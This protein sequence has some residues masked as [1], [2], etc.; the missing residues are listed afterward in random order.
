MLRPTLSTPRL[1]L[2]PFTLDDA[3]RITELLA[4]PQIAATTLN[5]P[6]PYELQMAIDWISTHEA[7]FESGEGMSNAIILC[8]SDQVIGAIGLGMGSQRVKHQRAR[9]VF[10][11]AC[12]IGS[13]AT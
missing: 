9:W 11:S 13:T 7:T 12:R 2:R 6:Y 1:F 8:E 10:G 5:I 4:P 3:P